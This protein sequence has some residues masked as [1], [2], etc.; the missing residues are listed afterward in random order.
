M[1]QPHLEIR[2]GLINND[3]VTQGGKV[4]LELKFKPL[5]DSFT[6]LVS[7]RYR[8]CT[9]KIANSKSK[10]SIC[11]LVHNHDNFTFDET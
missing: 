7:D 8:I 5:L 6:G 1:L 11:K 4:F 3:V 10:I 9:G 2:V